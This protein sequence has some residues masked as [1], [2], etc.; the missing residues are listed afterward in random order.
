MPRKEHSDVFFLKNAIF[1][2]SPYISTSPSV[3]W[4]TV[5]G[6]L[7]FQ[8][9]LNFIFFHC[10]IVPW[11]VI[12]VSDLQPMKAYFPILVTPSGITM[13]VREEQPLK[14]PAPILVKPMYYYVVSLCPKSALDLTNY[15][16]DYSNT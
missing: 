7:C 4:T 11:N 3:Q 1:L 13:E 10:A 5:A 8:L 16:I 12:E 6:I 2:R 14:A 9:S 15:F